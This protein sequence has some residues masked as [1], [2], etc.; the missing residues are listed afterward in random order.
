MSW[1]AWLALGA[2]L[3]SALVFLI[4]WL[5]QRNRVFNLG[6]TLEETKRINESRQTLSEEELESERRLADKLLE[7]NHSLTR[8]L[9]LI[10]VDYN[11]VRQR[12]DR[13]KLD[14]YEKL[15]KDHNALNVEL[16]RLLGLTS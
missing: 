15:R 10:E 6:L 11:K 14:E 7:V 5:V 1:Y 3:G 12:I 4:L 13:E 2:S 8:Q 16:D 9:E